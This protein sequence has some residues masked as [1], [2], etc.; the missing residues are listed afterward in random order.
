[1]PTL[2][3]FNILDKKNIR[4]LIKEEFPNREISKIKFL[5]RNKDD[6]IHY[7]G[8]ADV[9]WKGLRTKGMVSLRRVM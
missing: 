9:S 7:V 5:P 3:K 6:E 8:W 1:M 2:I 4:K